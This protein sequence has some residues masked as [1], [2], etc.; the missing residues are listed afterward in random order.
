MNA[1]K[2]RVFFLTRSNH[3]HS[4][5]NHKVRCVWLCVYELVFDYVCLRDIRCKKPLICS[6]GA[7][8]A[9]AKESKYGSVATVDSRAARIAARKAA[10]EE[11]PGLFGIGQ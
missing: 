10:G 8:P 4:L 6:V 9:K 1:V 2:V 5:V 11:A 3:D 7:K